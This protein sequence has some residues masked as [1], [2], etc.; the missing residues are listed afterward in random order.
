MCNKPYLNIFFPHG[1]LEQN[2]KNS[3]GANT[4]RF[5]KRQAQGTIRDACADAFGSVKSRNRVWVGRERKA[6]PRR[7]SAQCAGNVGGSCGHLAV[8]PTLKALC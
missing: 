4:A 6:G 7:G 3:K 2:T 8:L 1:D 5:L